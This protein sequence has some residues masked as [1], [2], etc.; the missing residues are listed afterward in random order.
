MAVKGKGGNF[1]ENVVE[2][3]KK[4]GVEL[5]D[6]KSETEPKPAQAPLVDDVQT[7]APSVING[8]MNCKYVRP[9]YSEDKDGRTLD[10]EFSFPLTDEHKGLL[11]ESV[12]EVWKFMVRRHSDTGRYQNIDEIEDQ[13][14]GVFLAPDI[15]PEITIEYAVIT[16]AAIAIVE[17]TGSGKSKKIYRFSFR[18]QAPTTQSFRNF[19]DL[20]YGD[21]VWITMGQAQG[22]LLKG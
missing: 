14:I 13:V 19:A 15:K 22:S 9:V 8:K 2:E 10:M 7:K 21:S 11:P 12:E 16:N 1:R 18:A 6:V 20:H 5:H 17:E 3:A 4:Q